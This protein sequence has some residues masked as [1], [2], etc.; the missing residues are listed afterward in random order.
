[1][2]DQHVCMEC[3]FT[4]HHDTELVAIPSN[5][6]IQECWIKLKDLKSEVVLAKWDNMYV[7]KGWYDDNNTDIKVNINCYIHTYITVN[8]NNKNCSCSYFV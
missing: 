5:I 7:F 2:F 6:M 3:I 4:S 1:M 8:I